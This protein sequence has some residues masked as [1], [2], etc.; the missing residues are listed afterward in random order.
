MKDQALCLVS[1]VREGF[2]QAAA[3]FGV[4]GS[5]LQT[6]SA[7]T[8]QTQPPPFCR[9]GCHGWVDSGFPGPEEAE[10]MCH[11]SLTLFNLSTTQA[12]Y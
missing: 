2:G 11:P 9:A 6:S 12:D 5:P 10:I 8:S 7:N 3:E 1:M 4:Q